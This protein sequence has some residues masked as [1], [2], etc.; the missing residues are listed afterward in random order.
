MNSLLELVGEIGD[1]FAEELSRL[2]VS[3]GRAIRKVSPMLGVKRDN[4]ESVHG[5]KEVAL[6]PNIGLEKPKPAQAGQSAQAGEDEL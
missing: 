6:T 2:L 1:V 4:R 5:P 3:V